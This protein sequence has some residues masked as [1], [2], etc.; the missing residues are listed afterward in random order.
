MKK[1]NHLNC[2]EIENLII[3]K[4]INDLDAE[5]FSLVEKHMKNCVRCQEFQA[6]LI[7]LN[8]AMK[9]EKNEFLKPAPKV[10]QTILNRMS[11]IHEKKL[12]FLDDILEKI[13]CI[14]DYR[15]PLYQGILGMM[16]IG[17][18]VWGTMS[19][20]YGNQQA[21]FRISVQPQPEQ[22]QVKQLNVLNSY[23]VLKNQKI[24]KSV[25]EDTM[26]IKFLSPAM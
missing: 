18:L 16:L 5:Q 20:P 1:V 15:I 9:I 24:G 12:S 4:N 8:R 17:L 26:L 10:Y 22:S 3:Q 23:E 19:L 11:Q 25:S 6:T 7:N 2:S 14:L 13:Y 21:Q